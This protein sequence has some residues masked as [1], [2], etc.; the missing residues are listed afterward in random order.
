MTTWTKCIHGTYFCCCT[1]CAVERY[2]EQDKKTL[3]CN[4]YNPLCLCFLCT[5]DFVAFAACVRYVSIRE[6]GSNELTCPNLCRA[7]CKYAEAMA[8]RDTQARTYVAQRNTTAGTNLFN[9]A[10]EAA[11]TDAL[12]D[13]PRP[14]QF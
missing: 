6:E 9:P 12:V 13:Q 4:P 14:I 10:P 1:P 11:A 8:K 7:P 5:L 2:E 3:G